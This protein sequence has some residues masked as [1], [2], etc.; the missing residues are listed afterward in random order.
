MGLLLVRIDDRLI[1]GQVTVGWA[2]FLSANH[3]VVVNDDVANDPMR[4]TLLQ[5][6]VPPEMKVDIL[7]VK[8]AIAAID[9]GDFDN[10]GTIL[11]APTPGD[12][13]GLLKGGV[14]ITSVNVGNMHYTVGKKQITK[15]VCV[16]EG[17]VAAF[18]EILGFN[19]ELEYRDVPTRGKVNFAELIL[20]DARPGDRPLS[21]SPGRNGR[22]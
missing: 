6:A 19:V 11:L 22:L 1:H 13:L 4:K 5:M 10:D 20:K 12:V 8:D 18:R 15:S 7:T 2:K 9:G 14:K 3:I 21:Q 17:D 16:D